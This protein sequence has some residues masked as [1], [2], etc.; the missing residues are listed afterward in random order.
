MR[1]AVAG[2]TGQNVPTVIPAC[3]VSEREYQ[4]LHVSALDIVSLTWHMRATY[5]S[6]QLSPIPIVLGDQS[7]YEESR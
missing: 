7:Q 5:I 4:T 3:L 2:E 1:K 6:S